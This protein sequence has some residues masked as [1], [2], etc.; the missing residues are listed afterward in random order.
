[1]KLVFHADDFGLSPAVN[2]GILEA[3]T[4][5]V[6]RSTS[7]M[8]TADAAAEAAEAA[9]ATPA[10]DVGLHLTLVEERPV[11]PVER[12]PSLVQ[13]GRFWPRHGVVALRY[14]RRRW[15]P[16]EARAE[17]EA[18]WERFDALG[19]AASHCDGHQHLHLLPGVFPAVAAEARRR[20]IR[21]VRSHLG[22][23]L[24]A[25]EAS[26]RGVLLVATH[27]VA[28]L[29]ARGLSRADRDWLVPFTTLGFLRAGGS[30]TTGT[31]LRAL[32]RLRGRSA[33]AIVEVMLHPGRP[34]AE[35]ECRYGHWGYR[36]ENDLALLLDPSLPEALARRGIQVTSFR[37]LAAGIA[38]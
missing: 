13:G 17:L 9:R 27:G 20:G 31:L 3:H 37:E 21:F 10:L 15:D 35:T 33:P 19:L 25:R 16:A 12:I 1:V 6:L 11:L 22:D 34:D 30:L 32:D 8:V 28:W 24:G 36:W 14:L 29:A 7:L 4:H 18:Q 26:P 38:S 2:A 5:G 23:P